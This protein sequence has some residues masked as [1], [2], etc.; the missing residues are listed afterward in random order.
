MKKLIFVL[1][2][3]LCKLSYAQSGKMTFVHLSDTHVGGSTGE[4]DLRRTV[5][6]I[7]SNPL[8]QFVII[9][10]DIT[11]FG[12]DEEIRLAKQLLDSLNKPWH[13]VPGNHDSNWSE[14]GSNTFK[15]VFGNET[16]SFMAGGYLFLGT[17]SGPNMRMSPGQIPRENIVWLDSVLQK[18]NVETPIIFMNH[19]PMDSSLN[20]WFEAIDL[21]KTKNI[22]LILHGH[23]HNNKIFNYEGIPGIMGR[24]NLRANKEE[25]GYNIVTIENGVVTYTERNPIS[26]AE[27]Q[28]AQVGIKKLDFSNDADRYFRP[29]YKINKEYPGVKTAWQFEDKSDI[30]SGIAHSDK[31]LIA[32]NTAGNIYALNA[33]TGKKK[34]NFETGGKIYSTPAIMNDR[35]V[36]ASTDNSIYCLNSKTGILIWKYETGRPIVANPLIHNNTVYIGSSEGVFRAIDLITG[37]LIW[38]FREVKN[39]VVT[40]PLYYQDKIYF[41]SWGNEFYALEAASG[42]LAWKW[43]NG[44]TNRMFSPAACYPVATE[45]KIFIVAPDR[46]MTVLDASTGRQ[47][48]RKNDPANRVR[49]SMGMSKDSSLIYAKTMEGQVIGVSTANPDMNITW[50]SNTNLGYE[51]APTAIVEDY[52]VVYIP[53]NSGVVTAVNRADGSILWKHKVSN[54]LIT[55]ISVLAK[56]KIV[57]NTMDGKITLLDYKPGKINNARSSELTKK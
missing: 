45:G 39:F 12:S 3:C 11:E 36:V 23:G 5:A 6:D 44:A 43:D 49:E 40:T 8:I 55:N 51:I 16:F 42:K 35:V 47:I 46:F 34:W 4:E 26:K 41:G 15:R 50:R 57:V 33:K 22:Q 37:K 17:H 56:N 13:I 20:N 1:L 21:L 48:W 25:G 24:S 7:N 27:K 54:A 32:S 31:L 52:N 28:W 14:S 29:S 19:Y 30:G 2:L 18:T 53:S 38:E 9:S 10:G